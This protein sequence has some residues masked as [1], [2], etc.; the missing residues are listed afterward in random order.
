MKERRERKRERREKN[1][2]KYRQ[3]IKLD[4]GYMRI[5]AIFP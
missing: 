4:K 2:T 1:V 3:W 5:L